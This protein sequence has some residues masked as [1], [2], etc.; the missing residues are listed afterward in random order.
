MTNWY[1]TRDLL[2]KSNPLIHNIKDNISNEVFGTYS[3]ALVSLMK[4]EKD[5]EKK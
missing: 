2:I 1:I 4:I 5:K 3:L